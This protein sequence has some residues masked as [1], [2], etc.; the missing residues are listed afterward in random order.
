MNYIYVD[1]KIIFLFYWDKSRGTDSRH[2]L[3]FI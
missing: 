3:N 2:H 1:F